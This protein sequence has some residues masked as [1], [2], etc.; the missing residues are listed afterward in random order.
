MRPGR[1]DPASGAR[2][3]E[4]TAPTSQAAAL[5]PAS[6]AQPAARCA[7]PSPGSPEPPRAPRGSEAAASLRPRSGAG[8]A[9]PARGLG[10]RGLPRAPS[11]GSAGSRRPQSGPASR[12]THHPCHFG[13]RRTWMRIPPPASA[14]TRGVTLSESLKR[15]QVHSLYLQDEEN[16]PAAF[17]GFGGDEDDGVKELR[18]LSC[19]SVLLCA[20][21]PS[22]CLL[23]KQPSDS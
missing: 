15:S 7:R 16:L 11:L 8:A 22:P 4:A 14:W 21:Y 20:L 13:V 23:P 6:S 10:R 2:T 19:D 17:I 18:F 9:P 3:A 1:R 5:A 12:P